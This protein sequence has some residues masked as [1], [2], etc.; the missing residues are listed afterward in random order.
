MVIKF[1]SKSFKILFYTSFVIG[2][3]YGLFLFIYAYKIWVSKKHQVTQTLIH[4][5]E[6]ATK[7]YRI[8]KEKKV[9]I[10]DK[11]KKLI[12]QFSLDKI[13]T[14]QREKLSSYK[15]LIWSLL[16]AEDKNFYEH[17]GLNLRSIARAVWIN[18]S[19]FSTVQ[20][21]STI[22]QQISKIVM[23]LGKRNLLNKLSE[24]F[25]AL[26][27]EENFDKETLLAIYMNQIFLGEGNVG[28]ESAS[29]YYFNKKAE[30]LTPQEAAMLVAIVPAPSVYNPVKNLKLALKKQKK[31][32]SAMRENLELHPDYPK[33]TKMDLTL[34]SFYKTYKVK[35][36]KNKKNGQYSSKIGKF[37]KLYHNF[38]I[39]RA[40]DFNLMLKNDITKF[41]S[42]LFKK[43]STLKVYTTLDYQKQKYAENAL[44]SKI[45]SIKRRILISKKDKSSKKISNSMNGGLVSIN[46]K[47]GHIEVLVG[48]YG[49]SPSGYQLNRVTNALRQPGSTIKA[50]TYVLAL[51]KRLITPST[52][53]KD[54]PININGYKP[55][56]WYKGYKGY[57]PSRIAFTQSINT[58]AVKLFQQVGIDSFLNK[59]GQILS[60]SNN[61]IKERFQKN[62]SLALGSGELTPLE[63]SL[64]Y[65]T[66]ANQ[67]Y[68]VEPIQ[69]LKIK[70]EKNKVLFEYREPEP[71][72]K[73]SILDPTACAI[74]LNFLQ[75]VLGKNGT[76]GVSFS[77]DYKPKMAGKTGTVQKNSY[78]RKK[79]HHLKGVKDTWF[80]GLIPNLVTVV[81]VG[82]D[83]GAPFVGSGSKTSGSIWLNYTKNLIYNIEPSQSLIHN[84]GD[85]YVQLDICGDNGKIL[86]QG[87][88]NCEEPIYGQY[89]YEE[90]QGT[91]YNYEPED[92]LV[93]K[94]ELEETIEQD[95]QKKKDSSINLNDQKKEPE[96]MFVEKKI[97]EQDNQKK[98]DSSIN[99]NDQK[100]EP[101]DMF[102][103]KKII[104]Q[105][106]QKKKDSL[107]NPN[108]PKEE[109]EEFFIDNEDFIED[110]D[111]GEKKSISEL[112]EIEQEQKIF[113]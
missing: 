66:I 74:V 41:Y 33:V 79:W 56:N 2:L 99:L 52:L 29:L 73:E 103:E 55:K 96:D 13:A 72:E 37:E 7:S 102:V 32:L 95:N 45:K 46:P 101:E 107:I 42:D 51:E 98:K 77:E 75:G 8:S 6:E 44:K 27:L 59:I 83:I 64:I 76:M 38:E 100:K 61:E 108:D 65:A 67:G 36:P 28:M 57:V 90:T 110:I 109:S 91:L 21:G 88:N 92:I 97:I 5:E 94:S 84:D 113:E 82:S 15:I 23:N 70:N 50:L 105:D 111:E 87:F 10:F 69:I 104:E 89:Y 34:K 25:C 14:I 39:N 58:I 85:D 54:E 71:Y 60:L 40:A 112:L 9:K 30:K 62:L 93:E 35:I 19:N 12:G 4:W 53:L 106:N 22:T 11:K 81:W 78:M 20:G 3:L 80:V 24:V 63:L 68:K 17:Y 31:V 18:L 43:N 49:K 16:S 47:N 26:F 1:I 48:S 86:L